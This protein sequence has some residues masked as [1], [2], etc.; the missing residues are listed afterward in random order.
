AK[1]LRRAPVEVTLVDRVNHHLFQPLLYQ[2]SAGILAE[3]EIAPPLRGILRRQANAR[4]LLA[5]ITGFDLDRREAHAL[6]PD[7]GPLT[8]P[9]D[10]LIVA[11]GASHSYFGRD[12]WAP[13]ATGLKTLADAREVR[14]R[15]L[16]AFE[17]AEIADDPVERDA[18]LRFAVIGGGP[19]G[20][21]LAGQIAELSRGALR[22]DYRRIDTATA[23]ISLLEAGADL[24][25]TWPGELSA[26]AEKDLGELGVDVRTRR[27]A[28]GVDDEGVDVVDA[29]GEQFR[30]PAR[31]VLWAAGVAPSPLARSLGA[32]L[33]R[34][35]RVIVRDD[36]TVPDRE[37]V[38]A[39]GDMAALD[40]VPGVAPAAMQQGRHAARTI[41][42]RLAGREEPRPF[43]Y[44]D[45]GS[46][47]V[48]GHDRAVGLAFGVTVTG[49]GAMLVWALVHV[50]HLVGWGNRLITTSRWLWTM[51][52]RNRAERVI[53]AP[54]RRPEAV[55]E[56][57]LR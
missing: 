23:A 20:I 12:E 24:L 8:L 19:T 55:P 18:W 53:D 21:E 4:V 49:L 38:F 37:E 34:Y 42:R 36:L 46:L 13:V 26:R 52:A 27:M 51:L 3:S 54:E 6:A 33:D 35:G 22:P 31:T 25:P 10:S 41:R 7:G 43:R 9:Y 57:S 56:P 15:I 50:R 28:V 40:G 32:Q 30:V 44:A 39:I 1:A 17:L 29:H 48:I 11:A 14:S 47:A 5:E 2:V 16:R 45:K